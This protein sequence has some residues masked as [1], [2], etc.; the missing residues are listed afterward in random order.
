[1]RRLIDA[2]RW[3]LFFELNDLHDYFSMAYIIYFGFKDTQFH[4]RFL[5]YF[6]ECK[7]LCEAFLFFSVNNNCILRLLLLILILYP[8]ISTCV[9]IYGQG[10]LRNTAQNFANVKNC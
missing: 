10:G 6:S 5:N 7:W 1:M 4:T 9:I 8:I 2:A 3:L